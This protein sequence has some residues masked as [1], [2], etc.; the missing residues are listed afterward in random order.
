[1]Q[2]AHGRPTVASSWGTSWDF[3]RA[4]PKAGGS[5]GDNDRYFGSNTDDSIHANRYQMIPET[6][7]EFSENPTSLCEFLIAC[8]LIFDVR[9]DRRLLL[10]AVTVHMVGLHRP[11]GSLRGDLG[12]KLMP[13]FDAQKPL[14]S[15]GDRPIAPRDVLGD[16]LGSVLCSPRNW[17]DHD[18]QV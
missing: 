11:R 14:A 17:S 1:M 7:D 18:W 12:Q 10:L 5:D 4:S 6:H 2:H 13:H 16:V 3:T 9:L 15:A 8:V